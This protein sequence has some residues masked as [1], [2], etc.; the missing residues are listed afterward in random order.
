MEL[1]TRILEMR[2]APLAVL[3]AQLPPEQAFV[4]TSSLSDVRRAYMRLA[5][6]VHPD[7]QPATNRAAA[8]DAFQ[9]LVKS[10]D[11]FANGEVATMPTSRPAPASAVPKSK[12]TRSAAAETS[13]T[14]AAPSEDEE[15]ASGSGT[16][17]RAHAVKAPATRQPAKQ[18]ESKKDEGADSKAQSVRSLF[19]NFA[20]VKERSNDGCFQTPIAC[21]NCSTTW[22]PDTPKHFTLVMAYNHKIYCETC[23][24]HYGWATANHFCPHC[25]RQVDYE[26][27][28]YN[29]KMHCGHCKKAYGYRHVVIDDRVLMELALKK[30]Q[31]IEAEAARRDREERLARRTRGGGAAAAKQD[32]V[33][34]KV[35]ECMVEERCPL[36]RKAVKSKHRQHVLACIAAG[37]QPAASKGVTIVGEGG[38]KPPAKRA[39]KA[40]TKTSAGTSKRGG[41][42]TKKT[43]K[44][45]KKK[46]AAAKKTKARP[47]TKKST[48]SN[49]SSSDDSAYSSS[50][51]C[52][53]SS[54]GSSSSSD[55]DTSSES[56]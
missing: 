13:E 10:F 20:P 15:A 17:T 43:T 28:N 16:A 46:P 53:S 35:G 23:L 34:L 51:S 19:P 55:D 41:G 30:Q 39:K 1:V 37:V 3:S 22:Q 52:A 21:P 45:A 47:K 36:C 4:P 31:E 49:D 11:A 48:A 33:D 32:D 26:P 8:T 12:K 7:K 50:S 27:G 24:L 42:A 18:R 38:R 54:G 25:K 29:R 56:A 14:E 44:A 40:A 2:D 9:V 5:L 6:V